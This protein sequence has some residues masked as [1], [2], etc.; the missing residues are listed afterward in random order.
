MVAENYHRTGTEFD[1]W[2]EYEE[3]VLREVQGATD[4]PKVRVLLD[5]MEGLLFE[6]QEQVL[7]ETVNPDKA[8]ALRQQAVGIQK[9]INLAKNRMS[10]DAIEEERKRR[11]S[12]RTEHRTQ[13]AEA[14]SARK[15]RFQS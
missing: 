2:H 1:T 10:A 11:L 5:F 9:A 15:N 3:A 13:R 8:E 4:H 6:L 12:G 7:S 14:L